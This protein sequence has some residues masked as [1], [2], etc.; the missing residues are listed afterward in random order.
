MRF[1]G[2][3]QGQY[4]KYILLKK[5]PIYLFNLQ[6]SAWKK[7]KKALDKQFDVLLSLSFLIYNTTSFFH[8]LTFSHC[9]G[10]EREKTKDFVVDTLWVPFPGN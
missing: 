2:R 10:K 4:F 3:N 7:A 8:V 5:I 9:L 6:D 1:Y